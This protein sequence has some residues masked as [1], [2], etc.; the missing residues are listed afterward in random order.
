MKGTTPAK[1]RE[2]YYRL[3][4]HDPDNAPSDADL[5][6]QLLLGLQ[7]GSLAQALKVY[8]CRNPDETFAGIRQEAL[9]LASDWGNPKP[10]VTCASVSN[11]SLSA[12]TQD[13]SWKETLK[14]EIMEDVRLQM[15]GLTQELLRE[16]IIIMDIDPAGF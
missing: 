4:R 7:E 5:R 6:D 2:L 8:V 1:F 12:S 15:S 3:Q 13:A 11:P 14:R 9:L 16:I 10:E